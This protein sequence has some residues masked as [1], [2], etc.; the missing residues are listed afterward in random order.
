MKQVRQLFLLLS[1]G[2]GLTSCRKDAE[3]N[4]PAI[5]K[6]YHQTAVTKFV[7]AGG[8]KYAY[9]ELGE[10]TG[11]PIVVLSPLASSMDDWDPSITNG[12]AAR[13]KVILF[14]IEGVGLSGGKTPDNIAGMANGVA[15]F[16]RALGLSKVNLLGFSMGS[17]IAQQLALTEPGLVNRIIL[18]GTGPKGAIGLSN[19]PNL[20]AAAANLSP[21]ESFLKF[22]FTGSAESI[23]AGKSAYERIHRR[24]AG[25]DVPVSGESAGAQL[26]AVLAWAQPAPDALNEL[27]SVTQ[28]VLIAQGK[29]DVPVPEQNAINMSASIPHSRLV[30]YPDAGHAA[31][32]QYADAFVKNA[33]DFFAE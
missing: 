24:V 7:N 26:K 15:G 12:L 32:F 25:R 11:I 18:T 9:R 19:L 5:V 8:V 1:L 3:A 31:I 16:I 33:I 22:G 4:P 27:K 28:P 29:E 21:E 20:L 14:D 10:S 6:D 2:L 23:K 17:F 30:I 13:Y